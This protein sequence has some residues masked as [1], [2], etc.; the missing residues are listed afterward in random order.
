MFLYKSD[1]EVRPWTSNIRPVG[2]TDKW[3][4]GECA[5]ANPKADLETKIYLLHFQLDTEERYFEAPRAPKEFLSGI[6]YA[7][8]PISFQRR[9]SGKDQNKYPK[10]I[11]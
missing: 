1:D 4:D 6:S 8:P 3:D 10:T 2:K 5:Q 11:F 7:P 9:G